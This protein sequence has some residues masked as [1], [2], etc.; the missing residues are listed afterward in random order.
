MQQRRSWEANSRLATETLPRPVY[1]IVPQKSDSGQRFVI[2]N[3]FWHLWKVFI[4]K[5]CCGSN[6]ELQ[7][8][9]VFGQ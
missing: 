6:M 7:T 9:D 2:K 3:Y 4:P 8:I 1:A 5:I